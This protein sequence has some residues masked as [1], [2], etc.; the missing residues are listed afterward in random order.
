MIKWGPVPVYVHSASPSHFGVIYVHRALCQKFHLY[1]GGSVHLHFGGKTT[2]ARVLYQTPNFHDMISLSSDIQKELG[3]PERIRIQ[4]YTEEEGHIRFGPLV[5]ILARVH[6]HEGKPY[7]M[8]VAVFE[9]LLEAAEKER[10]FGFIFSPEQIHWEKGVVKGWF[11]RILGERKMWVQERLPL[12]DVIYDQ[13]ISRK[14]EKNPRVI[15]NKTK[16]L[17]LYQTNYFNPGFFD[18]WQVHTWLNKDSR[19]RGYLPHTILLD[20]REKMIRF[21]QE[22]RLVYMKPIHGSLGLGIIKIMRLQDGRYSYQIKGKKGIA[23]EGIVTTPA[24]ILSLTGTHKTGKKYVIQQGLNLLTFDNR[25]F[26]IRILM[27]KDQT[28]KWRRTKAFCRIAQRGDITSNLSTGGNA[29]PVREVLRKICAD[30]NELVRIQRKIN[31]LSRMLPLVIEE[32]C[33]LSLGE[34]GLDIG[35]DEDRYLWVIEVNAK[36][37]KK[38]MTENGSQHLVVQSFRRPMLYAKYLSGFRS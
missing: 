2:K 16:L 5:G 4:M 32:Q 1:A 31:H 25:P 10:L 37:W 22:H 8:Q 28:G 19:M 14:Y 26:D 7:G 24:Q 29:L 11:R 12:P 6:V 33:G 18:K 34:L 15:E 9:R 38:P 36:P 17:R 23:K 27:Q 30:K 35:I 3:I 20:S 13:I 21:M